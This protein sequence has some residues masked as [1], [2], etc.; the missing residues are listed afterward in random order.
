MI[1]RELLI[2]G[3][4]DL[5]VAQQLRQEV[6]SC[7]LA[8]VGKFRHLAHADCVH[9]IRRDA[10]D[11]RLRRMHPPLEL[12]APFARN[13][14]DGEFNQRSWEVHSAAQDRSTPATPRLMSG[15][16]H[17]GRSG[18]HGRLQPLRSSI[19][20]PPAWRDPFDRVAATARESPA[21]AG[22]ALP[23]QFP[24]ASKAP[25]RRSHWVAALAVWSLP[26]NSCRT[27]QRA[28]P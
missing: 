6:V 15:R 8:R 16:E 17:E 2:C 11:H 1:A 25:S 22:S 4:G 19:H 24:R 26:G 9:G 14:D 7:V 27:Q 12:Y 3:V 18:G 23:P 20:N 5:M 28:R 21:I 10:H 13:H